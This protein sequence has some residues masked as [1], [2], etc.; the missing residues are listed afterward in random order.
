MCNFE[1]CVIYYLDI[2]IK[3]FIMHRRQEILEVI[4]KC[5]GCSVLLYV[6]VR[7]VIHEI[8]VRHEG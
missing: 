5:T 1:C 2:F 8:R 4:I 3:I 7:I 6:P